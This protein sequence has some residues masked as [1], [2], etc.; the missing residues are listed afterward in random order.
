MRPSLIYLFS[1]TFFISGLL[2]AQNNPITFYKTIS[3]NGQSRGVT[4]EE[5]TD[6]GFI[7]TGVTSDG[8]YGGDDILLIKTDRTGRTLWTKTFGTS[9]N[10]YGWAVRQ[11]KDSSYVI[12]GYSDGIGNGGMDI[13]LMK[14]DNNG[15]LLWSN[16][17]GGDKDDYGWDIRLTADGGYVIAGQTESQ[18][19]G[20]ID[21]CLL[22]VDP[23]GNQQWFKT[24]GGEKVDR[25]FSVQETKDGGFITAGITYSYESV[26]ANDR[27]GYYLKTDALGNQEWFKVIGGDQ[28]DVLHEVDRTDDQGFFFTGYGESYAESGYRDVYLFKTDQNGEKQWLKAVGTIGEERGIKGIQTS[29]GGYAVVGITSDNRNLYLVKSDKEGNVSWTKSIGNE[30]EVEFGYT[31]RETQDGG[32]ILTGHTENINDRKR[33]VILI[34]TDSEGKIEH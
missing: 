21:A 1:F 15:N 10:D 7:L 24:Y 28:Y 26:S 19:N 27:D 20:E 14:T 33:S 25:I 29:D 13:Y 23:S 16:S 18:G 6:G 30:N 8:D 2:N 12:A 11:T 32:F 3:D 17:Y 34:K 31:I 9:R 4:V 5:T 22:K